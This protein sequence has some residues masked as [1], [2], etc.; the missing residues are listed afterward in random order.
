MKKRTVALLFLAIVAVLAG[1]SIAALRTRWAADRICAMAGRRVE[2][3]LGLPVAVAACRI[4]PIGLAVEVERVR[5][6]PAAAPL[7]E[8]DAI[9]ATLAPIQALGPVVHLERLRLVRP[10]L[11][12][13]LQGGAGG[14]RA[15]GADL[16][17]RFDVRTLE[18]EGG[19]ARIALA[20]GG[21]VA[22]ENVAV[23]T[24]AVR[25][26]IRAL[27][28]HRTV[29][30]AIA[31]GP[32]LVDAGG[33]SITTS[34]VSADVSVA[35]D[36]S[37]AEI[38]SAEAELGG[39]RLGLRGTVRQLCAP[40]LELVATAAARVADALA[41]AGLHADA[42]GSASAVARIAG[43]A[44]DP[45]VDATVAWRD[46]RIAWFR[47]GAG[48]ADLQLSG[49]AVQVNRLELPF[50]G[51]M[52][53]AHGTLRLDR[54]L[55]VQGELDLKGVDLAEVLDRLGVRGPWMTVHLDGKATFGGT[56]SPPSLSA[57]LATDVRDLRALTRPYLEARGDRG[58][59]AFARGRLETPLRV[60]R[61]GLYVDGARLTVG[62]GT[63]NADAAVHFSTQ[64]GFTVRCSGQADLDA[65]GRVGNVPWRGLAALEATV[66]AAPYGNPHVVGHA[67]I[68]RLRFMDVDLGTASADLQ[69]DDF[70]LRIVGGE[71][72]RNATRYR[73]EAV[74]DLRRLPTHV[75]SSR[76]EAKG[77]LRDLFDAVIDWLP[78]TRL[79][80]DAMDG[81]VEVSGTATGPADA[82]DAEFQA[83]L[84]AGT[85]YGRGYESG[86]AEGRIHKGVEVRW[87]RAELRRGPGVVRA[88][89]TWGML[90]PFPWDLSVSV[91]G[92]PLAE[93]GVP[94]GAWSGSLAGTAE[95]AG[96]YEHPRVRFAANGAAVQLSGV[97]FGTVQLAGTIAD[98]DLL[99]TGGADGAWLEAEAT[100]DGRVP[101][102]A[103]GGLA[104]QDV[105]RLLPG[106]LPAGFRARV[107]G[108]ASAEGELAELDQAH[109]SVRLDTVQAGYADFRVES[110]APAVVEVSRG[111]AELAG[112]VLRGANTELALS[113]ARAASG[114]LDVT[115][116]GALDL[117]LLSG[118]APMLRRP[119]GRLALEA[120]VAG[121]AESPVLLGAGHVED[122]AFEVRGTG[123]AFSGLRGE[124]AFSQNRVLFDGL[125]ANVNGGR[126]RLQG[127]VELASFALSR[128][129]VEGE[130]DEVPVAIPAYL[131][132]TLSG[133]IEA[134]GTPD[135]ATITGRLRVVRARYT[136]NVDLEKSL[137][138]LR[139][140]PPPPPRAYD[141]AGEWLRFD[142]QLVADG[143][144]RVE[145]DLVRGTLTGEL[146]LTGSL[147]AP[148]LVGTLSMAEGSRAVFRGN[149]FL[150]THAVLDF[151]DRHKV[152]I[153]LDVHGESQVRD[154]QV[155]MHVFGSLDEPQ[156]TLTSSPA[157]TQPDIITLLS[158]GFTKHDTAASAGVGGVAT[159]AAAQ[160]L[161]SAS[162]LDE[163]VKRFVPRGG[164]MR[165]LSVRIT[166]AY[167]EGTGQVEP[168]AEFESWLLR[169]R[170]RLRY[171]APLAGA[172][173]GQKAQAEL[174]LGDHTAVQ[175]QWDNDNPDVATGDHGV[176]L[177]LRWEWSDA[178]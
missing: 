37:S 154:Y 84:G 62:R 138:E 128:L 125:E 135:A 67:R 178:R 40:R 92:M 15:C 75:V 116:T 134:A 49:G 169:D 48:K 5:V 137:L 93:L 168:R 152:A 136:A 133:R 158:L 162:G 2:L 69:Y 114:Q 104:L 68:E 170:L 73:G 107:A 109:A 121:T 71:G 51:G 174:R 10:R 21:R 87:D 55:P 33:R 161:F 147:A 177:K 157:L 120:H 141:R 22:V 150:L 126:A 18:I 47:P 43:P 13:A 98:R 153:A 54:A 139:R 132:A 12:I 99:V 79:V 17:S 77:R 45:R 171:Q 9:A 176:D 50:E 165:D 110:T 175:Y 146:T 78:R 167:S 4:D 38:S 112:L 149:E 111:R 65:L 101:F 57:A 160:A 19:A 103:K 166:S 8:A 90:P 97:S 16:L 58:V 42:E 173:R 96:S 124:L 46:A 24:I 36:L 39:V 81:D 123:V 118:I 151:T 91:A 164:V 29:R 100:L 140:R 83:R 130:L 156:V 159:A 6:G 34:A 1:G 52:A 95:L 53:V 89:G 108:E 23:R 25:R 144:V 44:R 117:R 122:A 148:G 7:F 76:F 56:L 80:R 88:A 129:R 127:E 66:G 155:Y 41:L 20:G 26:G 11:A 105:T 102:H 59:V 32:V 115:V 113:G 60:D 61:D 163:Q 172:A 64:G 30:L 27:G 70:L 131:P 35:L 74:L 85:V 82:V 3:A 106:T 14:E 143:D 94:G 31:A 119:A 142:L 28:T 63:L 72:A 86:R 145:N